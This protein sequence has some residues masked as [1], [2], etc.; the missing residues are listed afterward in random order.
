MCLIDRLH[1][2]LKTNHT[3]A[4]IITQSLCGELDTLLCR[5][6]ITVRHIRFCSI[7]DTAARRRRQ[8]CFDR[9]TECQCL[10][11]TVFLISVTARH[12]AHLPD[13]V[14][15][16]ECQ[17]S[18]HSHHNEGVDQRHALLIVYHA[19]CLSCPVFLMIHLQTFFCPFTV[20]FLNL[21]HAR[22][23]LPV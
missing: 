2:I 14:Q 19:V 22:F 3:P 10:Q 17:R 20:L 5:I 16:C 7:V 23:R 8:L 21:F 1:T 12:Q 13:T 9:L 4:I 15:K 6:R 11:I 18:D